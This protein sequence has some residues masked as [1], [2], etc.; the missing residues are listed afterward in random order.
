MRIAHLQTEW[1]DRVSSSGGSF[2]YTCQ[3]LPPKDSTL[4]Y[5]QKIFKFLHPIFLNETQLGMTQLNNVHATSSLHNRRNGLY[6]NSILQ[7][8]RFNNSGKERCP[9]HSDNEL[10]SLSSKAFIVSIRGARSSQHHL[11]TESPI[12]LQFAEGHID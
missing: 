2:L 8:T 3:L 10:D 1:M 6:N 7:E 11:A 12:N 9:L 5:S 4:Y